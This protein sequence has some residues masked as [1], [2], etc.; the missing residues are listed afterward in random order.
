M[1]ATL[2]ELQPGN[3]AFYDETEA[4][5]RASYAI[6]TSFPELVHVNFSIIVGKSFGVTLFCA[7]VQL[8]NFFMDHV[9][10]ALAADVIITRTQT[11]NRAWNFES[12]ENKVQEC[13]AIDCLKVFTWIGV[14]NT[15]TRSLVE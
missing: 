3:K 7:V 4:G 14:Y 9:I 2:V 10:D 5:F 8:A 15:G 11:T 13:S 1:T 12:L 6:L